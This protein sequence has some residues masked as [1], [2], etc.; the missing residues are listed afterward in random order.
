MKIEKQWK[1]AAK[2][3][4]EKISGVKVFLCIWHESMVKEV[5][6]LIQMG[7]A[8]FLDKPIYL[9]MPECRLKTLPENVRRLARGIETFDDTLPEDVA[10]ASMEAAVTRLMQQAG[11][12]KP[13]D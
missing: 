4:A 11:M 6:P 3:M 8:V 12:A 2:E 5:A 9:V 1:Q 7:L 13:E 10:R